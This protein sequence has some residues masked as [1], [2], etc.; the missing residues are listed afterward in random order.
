MENIILICS[1]FIALILSYIENKQ[2]SKVDF[3][4][5]IR[6]RNISFP[7]RKNLL[8]DLPNLLLLGNAII[9]SHI[10]GKDLFYGIVVVI[11][12]LYIQRIIIF[13]AIKLL[14]MKSS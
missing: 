1:F 2:E 4:N 13:L 3:I 6:F 9:I 8:F 12:A 11:L 14:L 5:F 10:I 7:K